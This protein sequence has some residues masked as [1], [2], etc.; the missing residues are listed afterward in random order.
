MPSAPY[1]RWPP[2][3]RRSAHPLQVLARVQPRPATSSTWPGGRGARASPCSA[4]ATSPTRPGAT[5]L[6]ETLVPA[7]PGPVPAR[8]R[9]W[10]A[11][12]CRRRRRPAAPA[13][14]PVHAVGGDLHDLQARRPDPQGA[15]PDLRARL[16]RGRP[17]HRRRWARI[18]NLG[19]DGRP[20]LGLDSRDLLEITLDGRPGRLPGAGAHLDAVVRR[21]RLQVRLRRDRAT[22]TP[23]WPTTSSR[24]RPACPPTRR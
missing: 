14:G 4:P 23:T 6:R 19:S 20:I 18:G 9:T 16:R 5:E 3:R 24:W 17:V 10:S 8:A 21:A 22:A 2:L 12:V 13:T 1:P 15:P 7:E 11:D